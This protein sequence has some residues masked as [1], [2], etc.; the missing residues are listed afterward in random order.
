MHIAREEAFDPDGV[1]AAV[2]FDR[3]LEGRSTELVGIGTHE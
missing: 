3:D 1:F 2:G